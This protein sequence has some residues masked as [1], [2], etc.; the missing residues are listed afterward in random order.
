MTATTEIP[1]KVTL[2]LSAP[3]GVPARQVPNGLWFDVLK[4][5]QAHGLHPEPHE[6]VT[7][8]TRIVRHTPVDSGGRLLPDGQVDND[9]IPD[10]GASWYCTTCRRD[11]Y[12]VGD[13]RA[14]HDEW[15]DGLTPAP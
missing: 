14:R 10:L 2:T 4:V 6:V 5:L 15:C 13:D 9:D 1:E 8:L 7:A 11:V 3:L 12:D